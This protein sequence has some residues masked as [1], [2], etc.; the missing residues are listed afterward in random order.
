MG[1]MHYPKIDCFNLS[2]GIEKENLRV[3]ADGSLAQSPHPAALGS[4]LCHQYITTD[5]AEC[6][7]ET[8]FQAIL[9]CEPTELCRFKSD[10]AVPKNLTML[11]RVDNLQD[12]Y[13]KAFILL[14]LSKHDQAP[15][16]ASPLKNFPIAL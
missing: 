4:A 1:E 15:V 13:L 16:P 9:N 14:N 3:H 6:L 8:S 10:T 12:C 11:S 5:F 2:R 7:P